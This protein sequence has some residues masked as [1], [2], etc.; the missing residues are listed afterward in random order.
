M[1]QSI[2][3]CYLPN[4]GATYDG[5]R[6]PTSMKLR[7]DALQNSGL[8]SAW[9][10]GHLSQLLQASWATLLHRYTGSEDICFG[11]HQ[12][13]GNE[14]QDSLQSS[15]HLDP[16]LFKVSVKEG[17]SLKTFFDQIKTNNSPDSSTEIDR[18]SLI[19]SENALLFNTILMI[20][21]CHDS[22]ATSPAIPLP[23]SLPIALPQEVSTEKQILYFPVQPSETYL[24]CRVRL[25]VKVLQEEVGIFF[26]WWNN[27]MPT[28]Q[29]KSIAGAFQH[30][31]AD[32]LAA[33]N[34]AVDDLDIFPEN[35]WSRVCEFNSVLPE[36]HERCIH[37]V[38]HERALLQPES[39]AV[40]AWD[41]SLTYKEL[42]CLS[43][44]VAYN[45]QE[46]GVGPEVC[47]ALC[48][49]KSVSAIVIFII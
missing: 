41:G 8:L 49:E 31:L 20:R 14:S 47:V 5:P 37:E 29:M 18:S 45:L 26:E 6:R 15:K 13:G 32:L 30:I 36:K 1:A 4:F 46:R 23:P 10:E 28:A 44:K 3:P 40:C 22:K 7:T 24:Q 35:D 21:I 43:S 9:S 19:S 34:T 12:I 42:D 38:I 2:V 25:H 33:N 17:V 39:E 27:D 48:F 11:Y 16:A